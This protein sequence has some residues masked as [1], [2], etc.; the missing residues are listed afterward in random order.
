[1]NTM[2]IDRID[3]IQADHDVSE[4]KAPLDPS[5]NLLKK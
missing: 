4:N 5:Y 2:T 1:M 3:L